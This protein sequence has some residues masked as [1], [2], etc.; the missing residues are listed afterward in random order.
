MK[1]YNIKQNSE[2][3]NELRNGVITGSK[4]G[5]IMANYGKAFGEMAK[6]YAIN[7][8][9]EQL[10][11]NK[12]QSEFYNK[13]MQRGHAQEHL[14]IALYEEYNFTEVS[15][16]GFFSNGVVGCSP[17][18]LVDD[19]GLIEIKSVIPTTHYA[20]MKRKN[21]DPAYKWQ[22]YFNLYFTNRTW[23]D[24]VSYCDNYQEDK[25]LFIHRLHKEDLSNE[26]EI[27][28]ARINEFIVYVEKIKQKIIESKTD[29][30]N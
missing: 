30:Y 16:G 19:D 8:A 9:I 3:W 15:K 13:D 4:I 12:I 22:F 18:G 10:T 6:K 27:M 29:N 24:F 21:V 5:C 26:F 2:E 20:N 11:K 17:D 7:L 28:N 1:F 23:I 25:K 14:A